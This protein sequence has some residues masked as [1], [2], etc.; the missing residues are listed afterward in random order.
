MD[1][2]NKLSQ[3]SAE[4]AN[5][6]MKPSTIAVSLDVLLQDA[7]LELMAKVLLN[8]FD[9]S[10]V[11]VMN[12]GKDKT[13]MIIFFLSTLREK[14]KTSGESFKWYVVKGR[15]NWPNN[16]L[17]VPSSSLLKEFEQ[18]AKKAVHED[19]LREQQVLESTFCGVKLKKLVTVVNFVIASLMML[20]F[21]VGS[22]LF[23]NTG[24]REAA[25][26]KTQFKTMQ[27]IKMTRKITKAFD[28]VPSELENTD[29]NIENTST[30][31]I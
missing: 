1:I 2:M 13:D 23:F 12:V 18:K 28:G 15:E 29:L 5:L 9:V 24:T 10:Y 26:V 7:P 31:T 8:D 14:C 19:F 22:Y 4:E 25:V 20:V 30:D 6:L 3:I 11:D 17:F 27:P 16:V 21:V